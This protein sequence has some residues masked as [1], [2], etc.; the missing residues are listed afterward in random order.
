MFACSF[1]Y[2]A[3]ISCLVGVTVRLLDKSV[4]ADIALMGFVRDMTHYV[5]SHI[6]EFWRSLVALLTDQNLVLFACARVDKHAP[7]VLRFDVCF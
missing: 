1:S 7:L 2:S 4:P 3:N 5:V 6:A